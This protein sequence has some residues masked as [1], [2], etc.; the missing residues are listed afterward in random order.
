LRLFVSLYVM[1]ICSFSLGHTRLAG[2]LVSE[3]GSGSKSDE[4]EAGDDDWKVQAPSAGCAT[5][6]TRTKAPTYGTGFDAAEKS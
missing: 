5:G 3:R 4:R 1:D 2:R 6:S